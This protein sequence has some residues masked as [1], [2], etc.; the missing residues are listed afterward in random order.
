M[1]KVIGIDL[2]TTNS[3]V[4][5]MDGKEAKIIENSE[6]ARTTPSM[7]AFTK[8]DE[9]LVGQPAKRQAVTNPEN[10][11]FAIKRLIGRRFNDKDVQ[12]MAS[13]APFKI[14]AGDN[15]DA[16]VEIN[17]EIMAPSQISAMILQKMKE[18]AESYLGEKVDQAVITVPAYFNDSQRQATK[19]AGKIAGLEVLRIINE[20]TAAAL[21]Y[22]LDKKS[23]GTIIVYDLGGGTFDVSVLEIGDGVFEVKS[24]NGDTFLGG[25]DFDT[26]IIE[27]LADEFKKEQGIDLRQDKLALQRLKEAAE[28]AKIELSSAQQ[29][30]VNLPFVTADASGPKHLN[31]KLSRA[32]LESLVDDLVKRTIEPVKAA[33]KD[34]GIKASNIDEV[35]MVGG[36]TRMPKIIET[37][38]DFFGKEPHKGVNPD[39]VVADGAAIQGGV[40]QGD[41]KDVLLLDVTPL[42]LG[43]ETL[44]GVF[45]R[46]IDRNTTIPTKKSQVFS[47]A[48]DNQSAVT[49]RVFQGE[50]EMAADNKILGQFDLVGIP[51]APRGIPQIEVT[52]DIDANGIVQV[53]A[54]DKATGKE[55]QIRIQASGGLSDDDIEKMV[56]D[57]ESNAETDK[58]RRAA[59]EARN[60]A[61][62]LIHQTQSTIA[63]LGDDV[64]EQEKGEI[65]KAISDLKDILDNEKAEPADITAK[66]DVLMQASMKLGELVYKKQQEEAAAEG[67]EDEVKQAKGKTPDNVVDADVIDVS[68]I[69]LE[70]D[71]E[72]DKRA[73]K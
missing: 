2:G 68:D 42:S 5:V 46:L 20:P 38:K 58:K 67:A 31:I 1:S 39:E 33:L 34:A 3:C 37:V 24:T 62:S 56:K 7:V 8:D 59:V 21:A 15:G 50:R 10:T 61:E 55:Q 57:A 64:P 28:K 53:S 43:I 51:G 14:V 73:S 6:G 36:M 29:T 47:T 66:T 18:T 71:E 27:Y 30:E 60:Q 19:D 13:K 72:D 35:V 9:R 40:L 22:G 52:F 17:G 4:A 12:E 69:K 63:D 41:V 45:T 70:D 23:S 65:D 25:E 48:E 44:G 16:C 32:K 26:R 11:V 54:K 49:I